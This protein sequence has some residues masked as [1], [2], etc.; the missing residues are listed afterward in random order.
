[1]TSKP[2]IWQLW[3]DPCLHILLL[4]LALVGYKLFALEMVS[5]AY[6][7][8]AWCLS[9]KAITHES[10]LVLLL[11]TIHLLSCVS[12]L[13]FARVT[14][15]LVLLLGLVITAVDLVVTHQLWTRLTWSELRQ[16]A[17]EIGTVTGFVQQLL[18]SAWTLLAGVFALAVVLLVFVRYVKDDRPSLQPLF[19]YLL[20]GVGVVGC[21]LVERKEYH[22]T[23]LQ[24]S[25][26]VFFSR[27]TSSTPYSKAF[28]TTLATSPPPENAGCTK[29]VN[30][31]SDVILLVFESLSMYH[32]ALFSG[33]NNWTPEFDAVSKTGVRFT[34]FYANGVTSEQGLVALLTGEPPIAKGKA[35]KT[36]F[37]QFRNPADS[38]PRMLRG[39]GYDTVFLTTGNLG[40]LGKG[41]WLKDIGFDA[42][43]GHDAQAYKGLKRYQF[44][45]ASDDAL[46]ARA[47]AKLGEHKSAPVFMALET[48][49][50]HLP[51]VDPETGVHS[52]ELT[53]RYADRQLG[54]FVRSLQA[55]GFF[56]NGT[57]IITADHRAMVPLSLREQTLYGDRAFARV[58]MTVVGTGLVAR[59]ETAAFSHTD[60]LPS[61]RNALGTG[62]HCSKANQGLFLPTVARAPQ[63]T[64]TNRSYDPNSVF[65]HCGAS[66]FTITLDGDKTQFVDATAP[67][68]GVLTELHRLRLGKGFH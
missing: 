12:R 54:N 6:M 43:E 42:V 14:L 53:Y 50:T 58:P 51:N 63:C 25:I 49:T 38:V 15:R 22:D 7:D 32:S 52:Q 28:A 1:M 60:L 45:A 33:I 46:Y 11:L 27:P 19:L 4:V 30:T 24:N 18:P 31:R 13:R 64:Y 26:Q 36:L 57:L 10:K 3:R 35:A 41:K 62:Q 61:L 5:R 44:D 20:I 8:C 17:G 37:E 29:A 2:G 23:F 59:E 34:N 68:A 67:P 40:F 48:V 66:D 65:V 21:E 55:R 39:L 16:F 56:D 9:T 47:L